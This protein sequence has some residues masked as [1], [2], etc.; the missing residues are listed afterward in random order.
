MH[1]YTCITATSETQHTVQF[2]PYFY[3]LITPPAPPHPELTV[4][5][6]FKCL[7]APGKMVSFSQI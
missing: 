6:H 5:H 4:W 7:G 2:T 1:M 3:S